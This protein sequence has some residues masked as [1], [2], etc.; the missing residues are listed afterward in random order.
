M[1]Q[2]I[3]ESTKFTYEPSEPRRLTAHVWHEQQMQIVEKIIERSEK[4]LQ[5]EKETIANRIKWIEDLKE[6]L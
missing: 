6:S 4:Q 3:D 1:L 5:E 2:Q